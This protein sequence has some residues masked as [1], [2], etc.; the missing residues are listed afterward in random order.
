MKNVIFDVDDTLYD[1]MEPFQKPTK[2]TGWQPAQMQ[3]VR[4]YLKH[5]ELTVMKHSVCQEKEK[6]LKTEEFAYRVQK[7]YADVGVEGSA[8]KRQNNSK[9]DTV[10]T[11]SIFRYQKLQNRSL[12][13]AKKITESEF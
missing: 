11:K 7:T 9:N 8:K 10:I 4:N 5:Q 2:R 13:I 12:I 3:T 1:L 6:S